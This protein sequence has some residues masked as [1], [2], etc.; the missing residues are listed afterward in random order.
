MKR[1][2]LLAFAAVLLLGP[3][4]AV[5]TTAQ[6]WRPPRFA[7][8]YHDFGT[9][10]RGAVAEHLFW[11]TNTSADDVHVHSVRTTCGCTT[12]SVVHKTVQSGQRGAI[13]AVFNTRSFIGQRS[14]TII[15]VFDQPRYAEVQLQV[16]G[17]TRCDVV[18]QP[19]SVDFGSVRQGQAAEQTI[20][21]DYAGRTDWRI[22]AIRVPA[23]Y[24]HV[25]AQETRRGSGRVRYELRVQLAEDAPPGTIETE[26]T[27]ETDDRTGNRVPLAVRGQIVPPLSVSPAL[28]Y[29]GNTSAGQQLK[30]RLVVRGSEPFRITAVECDDSRFQFEIPAQTKTLHFVPVTFQAAGTPGPLSVAIRI[31]T[32][33]SGAKTSEV[34]ASGTVLP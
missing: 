2:I 13:R 4:L 23:S 21:V 20:G 3:H 27:L 11:F 32:D 9:V 30:T 22:T 12:P 8:T 14:A 29:L 10:A 15:V 34:T 28:L 24:F 25:Q 26:L 1:S 31:Q 33:L 16:R 18:L 5:E 6:T 7:S 19:G 17:F